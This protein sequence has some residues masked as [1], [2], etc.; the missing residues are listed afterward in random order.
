MVYC[1]KAIMN[2]ISSGPL[3]HA[4][5]ANDR[6]HHQVLVRFPSLPPSNS[7][8][9]DSEGTEEHHAPAAAAA[10]GGLTSSVSSGKS[11][12]TSSS[13]ST[14]A[15]ASDVMGPS[16]ST[17]KRKAST[18]TANDN[19]AT[20]HPEGKQPRKLKLPVVPNLIGLS[21]PSTKMKLYLNELVSFVKVQK[22]IGQKRDEDGQHHGSGEVKEEGGKK[23]RVAKLDQQD[24]GEEL[25]AVTSST[26][27]EQVYVIDEK[28]MSSKEPIETIMRWMDSFQD[29]EMIQVSVGGGKLILCTHQMHYLKHM[30]ISNFILFIYSLSYLLC[31]I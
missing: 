21:D 24:D 23:R 29:D 26:A 2:S 13:S 7:N 30:F 27:S 12:S 6:H 9:T 4:P 17:K 10:D 14:A 18:T 31:R 20:Q 8:P 25:T 5:N 3:N 16:C 22:E 11:S 15:A 28:A 19:D 1:P